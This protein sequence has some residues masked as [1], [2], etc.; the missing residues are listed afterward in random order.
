MGLAGW[1]SACWRK[2]NQGGSRPESCLPWFLE[3]CWV[4][5]KFHTHDRV[6]TGILSVPVFSRRSLVMVNEVVTAGLV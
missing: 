5:V 2:R 1:G 4:A 6:L 3:S